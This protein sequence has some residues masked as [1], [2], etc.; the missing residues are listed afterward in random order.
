[1]ARRQREIRSLMNYPITARDENKVDIA[2]LGDP[3]I[4]GKSPI[5]EDYWFDRVLHDLQFGF[6][7]YFFLIR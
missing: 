7:L 5:I 1:L 6:L 2:G 3:E 4:G